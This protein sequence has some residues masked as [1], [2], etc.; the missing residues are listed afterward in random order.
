MEVSSV[1]EYVKKRVLEI[2]DREKTHLTPSY[3]DCCR[4]NTIDEF[5]SLYN[6][7]D[8]DWL[9]ELKEARHSIQEKEGAVDT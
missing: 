5:L 1:Q 2:A 7:I 6:Q 8:Q 9:N 3:H 4:K